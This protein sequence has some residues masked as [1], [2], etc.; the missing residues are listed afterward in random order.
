MNN[1]AGAGTQR[2]SWEHKALEMCSHLGKA[3]GQ[4]QGQR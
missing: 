4:A 3:F 2:W 1:I